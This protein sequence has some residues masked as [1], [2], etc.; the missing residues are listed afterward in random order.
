MLQLR[1]YQQ[2]AV[3]S[4]W[5]YLCN[6]RGNPVAC[7]PCGAGKSLIIAQ[8]CK[9]TVSKFG[10]RVLVITHQKELISQDAGKIT[11]CNPGL[12][13]GI[14]SAGLKSRDTEHPVVVAGIQSAF[15]RACDFGSRQLLIVDE[16]HRISHDEDSMY[17]RFVGDLRSANPHLRICGLTATAFRLDSGALCAPQNLFQRVCYSANIRELITQGFLCN[18]TTTP[19]AATV[20]TSGL[21]IRAGEFVLQEADNLFRSVVD[22]AC[23]EI[24]AKTADRHSILVFCSG[25]QHAEQVGDTITK[26]TGE[27]V[28]VVT[29]ET[30]S[31]VRSAAIESFK[32]GS[33]RWLVC[34]EIFTTGFDAPN[35]DAIAALRATMSPGLWAQ[36]A[37]RGFRTH[38]SKPFGALVLDFGGNIKRH[39]PLDS[40][41]YGITDSRQTVPGEAPVKTCPNCEQPVL[42]AARECPNCGWQ[43]PQER[44]ARHDDK[45]AADKILS[46]PETFLVEHVGYSRHVKRKAEP[47]DPATLRVDYGCRRPGE[48]EGNLT[49]YETIS[50][51]C[52]FS[53][54]VGF[55]LTKAKK[56]WRERSDVPVPGDVDDAVSLCRRG[57]VAFARSI[58]VIKQGK[59][60]RILSANLEPKPTEDD[61]APEESEVAEEGYDAFADEEETPF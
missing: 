6:E 53:H 30:F 7:L 13:V 22:P 52:C 20:D 48:P 5:R 42:I 55:A 31:M 58:T 49:Q 3:D 46:E 25:V 14:Y 54:P 8:L 26:L 1:P 44:E 41:D 32:A 28:A 18:L 24:V 39:G 47:G 21:H 16:V 12:D 43:F 33:L 29:G 11:L 35:I 40:P 36:M 4:V 56:W 45:A 37:G 27:Q 19:A 2:A 15:R 50:E 10:G 17:G 38:P 59:F 51:W 9:D 57:A 23:R 34:C 60:W 61:L